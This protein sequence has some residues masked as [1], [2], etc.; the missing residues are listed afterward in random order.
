MPP[1]PPYIARLTQEA[2]RDLAE[3]RTY[4]IQRFGREQWSVYQQRIEAAIQK[5][6]QTPQLG[7]DVSYLALELNRFHIGRPKGSHYL[8][9]RLVGQYLVLVR[10]IHDAQSPESIFRS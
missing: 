6:C 1:S 3:I 9:Y 10:V 5:L 2:K 4:T 8:Y 7:R